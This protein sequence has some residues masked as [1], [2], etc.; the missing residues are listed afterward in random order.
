MA[1]FTAS[2]K[3]LARQPTERLNR[4]YKFTE[5][6]LRQAAASGNEKELKKRMGEHRQIE[7]ALLYKETPKFKRGEK[8]GSFNIL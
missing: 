5:L 7:Y 3:R 4:E 8:N 2:Q 1:F 6:K